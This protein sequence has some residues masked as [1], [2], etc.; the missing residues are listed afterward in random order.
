MAVSRSERS[1][2]KHFFSA[3][4][5][6]TVLKRIG[7]R[8]TAHQFRHAA[9]VMVLKHRRGNYDLAAKVLGHRSTKTT[10]RAYIGLESL[11]ANKVF[12]EIIRSELRF[13]PQA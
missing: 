7:L 2:V 1:Q 12:A 3:Q 4:I 10:H 6:A 11:D 5:S 13:N 8:I 9:A